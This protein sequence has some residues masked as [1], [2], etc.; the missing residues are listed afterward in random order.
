MESGSGPGTFQ[1]KKV[2]FFNQLVFCDINNSPSTSPSPNQHTNTN[3]MPGKFD[4][5]DLDS[6]MQAVIDAFEAHPDCQPPTPNPTMFFTYDFIRN[7]HNQLKAIDRSK[8]DSGDKKADEAL[9][10]V[11]GRNSFSQVLI[12]NP[13]PD[14]AAK[15]TGGGPTADFGPDIKQKIQ[16]LVDIKPTSS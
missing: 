15:L 11:V 8:Y 16:T 14:M 12:T 7:S 9:T 3:I 1:N 2:L 5:A 10:E 4:L 13:N 6:R